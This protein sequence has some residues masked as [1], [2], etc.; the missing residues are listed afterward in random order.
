[1][2]ISRLMV[3]VFRVQLHLALA[4]F[5]FEVLDDLRG[6]CA[7]FRGSD[8]FPESQG[9]PGIVARKTRQGLCGRQARA[10]GRGRSRLLIAFAGSVELVIGMRANS[11]GSQ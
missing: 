11:I 7:A 3:G 4:H 6:I 8:R 1:M 9:W 10:T 5:R 2:P